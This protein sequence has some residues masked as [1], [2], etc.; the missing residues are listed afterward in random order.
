MAQSSGNLSEDATFQ[1]IHTV[2][3]TDSQYTTYTDKKVIRFGVDL[4]QDV[5]L[6]HHLERL[7]MHM[8]TEHTSLSNFQFWFEDIIKGSW[9]GREKGRKQN[10]IPFGNVYK[11]QSQKT[12]LKI[13]GAL[14]CEL[15]PRTSHTG[16]V[17]GLPSRPFLCSENRV[18]RW[19]PQ[20]TEQC[21]GCWWYV[22]IEGMD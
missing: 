9:V 22:W 12:E 3:C 10:Y 16:P 14:L 1:T 19:H 18:P 17:W 15:P 2:R 7:K 6:G 20:G 13:E 11:I 21:D 8:Q 4:S 5:H